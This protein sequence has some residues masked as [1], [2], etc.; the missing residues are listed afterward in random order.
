MNKYL[1]YLILPLAFLF[2][3]S[4]MA[5]YTELGV[6]YGKK[7]T[8]FD[9]DN[10]FTSESLTGS[11]SLYFLE[12]LALEISYTEAK[13]I[14]EEKANASDP[15]RTTY[16]SS[17]V[18][19]ADLIVMFADKK[20]LFQPYVKGGAAQIKRRQEVKIDGQDSYIIEPD[21]AIVPSYGVGLKIA[22]TESMNFKISYDV[23]KTPVD[24]GAQT[25]DTSIRAGIT[26]IL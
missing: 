14:R 13:G 12:R 5:F 24:D 4:A 20:D 26:W 16:Q 10:Y 9:S 1:S 19:G 21:D 22:I 15:R 2:S 23:W 25:D 18:A 6:Q 17:T 3:T 11:M 8:T 7:Q